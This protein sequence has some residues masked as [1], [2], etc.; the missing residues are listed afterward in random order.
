[1]AASGIHPGFRIPRARDF[2]CMETF[3]YFVALF[4]AGAVP[5][6]LVYLLLLHLLL[7]LWRTVGL[8]AAQAVLWSAVAAT[9]LAAV[10]AARPFALVDFGPNPILFNTGLVCLALAVWLRLEISRAI[11]WRALAGW[12]EIDPRR[13]P[14]GLVESGPYARV[15][16]PRYLQALLALAGWALVA[17]RPVGYAAVLLWVPGIWIVAALE[18]RELLARFGSVF[19]AYRRRVPQFLP[20]RKAA[21]VAA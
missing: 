8:A 11:G 6:I 20:R 18:E 5:A 7:G 13:H 16:H 3:R 19:E 9:F 17:N 10:S 1:M 2:P 15:R 12:P 21:D 14:Q 4:L